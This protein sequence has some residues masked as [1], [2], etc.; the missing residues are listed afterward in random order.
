[1][2]HY[3]IDEKYRRAYVRVYIYI[4]LVFYIYIKTEIIL[5]YETYRYLKKTRH[6][7]CCGNANFVSVDSRLCHRQEWTNISLTFLS[8]STKILEQCF[9]LSHDTFCPVFQITIYC[10]PV[11]REHG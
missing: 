5:K 8:P 4:F 2:Q 6:A 9:Y 11:I 7:S 10:R 3:F 1:M